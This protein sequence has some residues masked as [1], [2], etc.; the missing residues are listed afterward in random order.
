M[1][2]RYSQGIRNAELYWIKK[3][4]VTIIP[5]LFPLKYKKL[6]SFTDLVQIDR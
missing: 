3:L 5:Q 2:K 4:P 1:P 6:L